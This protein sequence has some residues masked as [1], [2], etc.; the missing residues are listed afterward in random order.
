VSTYFLQDVLSL[1]PLGSG[2]RALP[3]AVTM[4]LGA[5]V[6]AVLLRRYGP[7]RTGVAGMVLV[8][9]GVFA[10]SRLDRAA[11][12]MGIGGS[13]LVIGAGFV[14]VMVT[15]TAVVVRQASVDGAGVAGGLQQTA[16][17]IGP[18]V[19]VAAATM[20]MSLTA[21]GFAGGHPTGDAF[22]PAMGSTLAVLAAVAGL[23][24]LLAVG[25]P[26]SSTPAST[27]MPSPSP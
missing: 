19:G 26:P 23:G 20:L 27:P 13:F 18:A 5:P 14:T 9:A 15:A 25:L 22:V 4:V 3:L 17:N 2:L 24:A 16:M 12:V 11:T 6:C 21:P 10:F 7:R 8:A 1:D